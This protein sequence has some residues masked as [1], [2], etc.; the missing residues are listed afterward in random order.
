MS[1]VSQDQLSQNEDNVPVQGYKTTGKQLQQKIQLS[2]Y[3]ANMNG[4]CSCNDIANE[5]PIFSSNHPLTVYSPTHCIFTHS[6]YSHPLSLY[7]PTHCIF[8]HSLYIHQLTIQS[9]IH[10]IVTHPLYIHPLTLYSHIHSIVTHPLYSHTSTQYSPNRCVFTQSLYTH[11]LS[12]FSPT[13][14][15]VGLPNA[16]SE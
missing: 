5:M 9:H 1:N 8:T 14:F 7:S 11:L 2:I 10:S 4:T 12:L 15:I 6:L 16:L 3:K 13:H